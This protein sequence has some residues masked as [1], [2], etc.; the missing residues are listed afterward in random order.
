M[1][2]AIVMVVA[3]QDFRDE[4]Y[5]IPKKIFQE[6]KLQV[7]TVSESVK[8]ATGKLGGRITIDMDI[9]RIRAKDYDSI[10]FVGGPGAKQFIG[11]MNINSLVNE[12]VNQNK[13]V[14]AI[15]IAPLILA[16]A[17]VLKNRKATVWDGDGEHYK[18]FQSLEIDYK[19]DGVVYDGQFVTGNGPEV[20][21][22]FAEKIVE[23]L[24]NSIA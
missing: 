16:K 20:A 4:E 3:P 14:C 8:V 22:E 18:I 24:K 19:K 17:G 9:S 10:V 7:I 5:F 11:D 15:C 1:T 21:S 23:I 13:L 12:F 6:N 2:K